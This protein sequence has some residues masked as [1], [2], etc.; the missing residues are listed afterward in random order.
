MFWAVELSAAGTEFV[1]PKSDEKSHTEESTAV[2]KNIQVD[3]MAVGEA[4]HVWVVS[5]AT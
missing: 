4:A 5:G 1:G 3:L 2:L